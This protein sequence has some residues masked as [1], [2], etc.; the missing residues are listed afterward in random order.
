MSAL[1]T[2]EMLNDL[3]LRNRAY[4]LLYML[5]DAEPATVRTFLPGEAARLILTAWEAQQGERSTP[6]HQR[7]A[8]LDP[9]RLEYVVSGRIA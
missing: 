1:T 4:N 3:K 5:G 8:Q 9:R 6:L 2:A 7:I